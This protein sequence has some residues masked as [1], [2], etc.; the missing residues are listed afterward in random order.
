MSEI[1]SAKRHVKSRDR[2][3]NLVVQKLVFFFGLYLC[4]PRMAHVEMIKGPNK[5]ECATGRRLSI[6]EMGIASAQSQNLRTAITSYSQLGLE[7]VLY[8]LILKDE[9]TGYLKVGEKNLW[10]DFAKSSRYWTCILDFYVKEQRQGL[11]FFLFNFV[12][13]H[14]S[15]NIDQIAYDKPSDRLRAFMRKH[16]S[17]E[18]ILHANHFATVEMRN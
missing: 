17:A 3:G 14:L 13:G 12:L 10:L 18:F 11:G 2:A 9:V 1:P 16:F 15:V 5:H 7:Q 8:I 4:I 6:D